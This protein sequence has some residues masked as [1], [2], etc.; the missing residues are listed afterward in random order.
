MDPKVR[1]QV[2]LALKPEG[3][4]SRLAIEEVLAKLYAIG[5][6]EPDVDDDDLHWMVTELHSEY[7]SRGLTTEDN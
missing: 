1:L 5:D 4:Y 2:E 7:V 3:D 6:D